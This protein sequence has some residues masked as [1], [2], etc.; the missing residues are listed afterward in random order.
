[1]KHQKHPIVKHHIG[2]TPINSATSIRCLRCN[3]EGIATQRKTAMERGAP[4]EVD[5]VAVNRTSAIGL[6]YLEDDPKTCRWLVTPIYRPRKGHLEGEQPLLTG[7][8]D[9]GYLPLT[10]WDDPPSRMSQEVRIKGDRIN[11]L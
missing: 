9:H 5:S 1:M 2:E 11:G 3:Q 8:T 7:H 10:N 4:H 6:Y